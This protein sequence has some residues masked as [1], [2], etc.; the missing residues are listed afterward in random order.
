MAR[1]PTTDLAMLEQLARPSGKDVVDIGCGG[2]DLVRALA[3]RGARPIGVEISPEQLAAAVARDDGHADYRVGRA[4][5]LPIEDG[6]ADIVVFMRSLHHV[7]PADMTRALREAR[8]V[9]RPG[10]IVYV[11]EPL[12]EGDY[13]A[14][15]SLVEEEL[16]VRRCAQSA[17]AR[18]TAA[19][20][21]RVTTVE[22]DVRLRIAGMSALRARTVSV[23]PG[24]AGIFDARADEIAEAFASL[25]RP[26]EHSGE[27]WFV[28]P[29]RADVLAPAA[30]G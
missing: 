6:A 19:G 5:D 26:G 29:M 4:Q 23:D 22:Y 25:G 16:E 12:P 1:G 30:G 24:R 15:T 9:V 18:G 7:P 17:L 28:Q 14:L 13:F 3:Q 2:G 21:D 8:R 11:A 10:G 27:R 20:L